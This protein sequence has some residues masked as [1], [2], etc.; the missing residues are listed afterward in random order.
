VRL[1]RTA[2]RF[3]DASP[4]SL[5]SDT[6]SA[7]G[8]VVPRHLFK[9]FHSSAL[10]TFHAS[11]TCSCEGISARDLSG[12]EMKATSNFRMQSLSQS[13]SAAWRH[14]RCQM[15][16][17]VK[18]PIPARAISRRTFL[19]RESS[20]QLVRPIDLG[21]PRFQRERDA[22]EASAMIH[23][24]STANG[25]EPPPNIRTVSRK[26]SCTD[27]PTHSRYAR[28]QYVVQRPEG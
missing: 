9:P 20:K 21:L 25:V 17:Q 4:R 7:A 23:L 12:F 8:P 24:L 5:S 11:R 14:G 6:Q 22:R 1:N 28:C 2:R 19:G 16:P 3:R 13:S 15:P 27:H 18:H 26:T 10:T